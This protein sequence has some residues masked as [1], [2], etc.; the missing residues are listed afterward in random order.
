MTKA[1]ELAKFGRETPPTGVV[2]GDSDT[3]TL[4][5]KTFS[6]GPVFSSGTV[7]AVPYLNASKVFSTSGTF[8]FDGTNLGVGVASPGVKVDVQGSGAGITV[9]RFS[10]NNTD[11]TTALAVFQRNGGAVSASVKYNATNSPLTI[12]FGTT[13]SHALT[14][15]TADTERMRIASGGNVGIGTTVP[16]R[17]LQVGDYSTSAI[18]ALGSSATSTGTICFATSDTAPGRY[19]GTIGYNHQTNAMVFGVNAVEGVTINS[20]GLG[21]GA[22]PTA[23]TGFGINKFLE[24][25]GASV[26]G[27]V[28]RP[29]GSTSE[30]SVL[31]AGDGLLIG[32]AGAATATN[33]VI[34]F[35]TS[36]VNS[37]NASLG[38]RMRIASNGHI[39]IGTTNP[40]SNAPSTSGVLHINTVDVGGWAITHYTN[41][42]TGA[43]AGDGVIIGNIGLDTYIFNY[44]AG[45]IIFGTSGSTKARITSVGV[46]D[47]PTVQTS[48]TPVGTFSASKW[49]T[50]T[51]DTVTT[52][53]YFCGP[54]TTTYGSWEIYNAKSNGTPLIAAAFTADYTKFGIPSSSSE[55]MRITNVGNLAIGTTANTAQK[56]NVNGALWLIASDYASYSTIISPRLDSTHPFTIQTR[57]NDSTMVNWLGIYAGDAGV[58]NRIVLGQGG[59]PVV[60]GATSSR[61]SAKLDIRGDIMV[62]GSNASYY[63]TI[64]YSAGTGLLSLAAENG[65]GISLKSGATERVRITPTGNLVFNPSAGV[66]P[67]IRRNNVNG[68]NGIRIQA[69]AADGYPNDANA[70]SYIH[71]AGGVIGDTYEGSIDIVAYG[72]IVDSNRNQIRFSNRSGTDTVQERMRINH[73]GN[74]GIGTTNPQT[75]FDVR[76]YT[77]NGTTIDNGVTLWNPSGVDNTPIGI[78]FSTYGDENGNQHPKQFIG[79]IRDGAYGAGKGSIVFCNRDAAD[80]SVVTLSDERMRILPG[81]NVGI[82]TTAPLGKLEVAAGANGQHIRIG[83]NNHDASSSTFRYPALSYY[84]RRDNVRYNG[85]PLSDYGSTASIVFTDRPGT[86]GY[87]LNCRSSDIEFWTATNT[88]GTGLDTRPTKRL[89]ISAEGNFLLGTENPNPF[90][91]TSGTGGLAMRP[92]RL[93]VSSDN[94][95]GSFTKIGSDGIVWFWARS[96]YGNVGNVYVSSSGTSYNSTSDYRLKNITGALTGY[97]ERLMGLQP[98]QGTWIADGSEFRGFLAHD[99]ANQYPK[100]VTGE[101]DEIDADG[102]PIMQSMQASTAEVM[103]DLIAMVKDLITENESLKA[104]LDAANL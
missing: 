9:A 65:G 41:G 97:K 103:A 82:G 11:T 93:F 96:G 84:A 80:T 20:N 88:G 95:C 16:Y 79:A 91:D 74:V 73:V 89:I 3:Q 70:G 59:W 102:K 71:L 98:K 34:R 48:G 45:D 87:P 27:L 35:F 1:L 18:M 69:N 10:S 54:N 32:A 37:S 51:E 78:R 62:L 47:T 72:G 83:D 61:A 6:D 66:T 50:Q 14:F 40:I 68:S 26:P 49:F 63:A 5:S 104:R 56:L 38:E 101:K 60:I 86:S 33:N 2:V 17:Q 57:N 46:F 39:G 92:N 85:A 67:V 100:S 99:F 94:D 8:V 90:T 13:T 36:N 7:N 19:V 29:T 53:T 64:D 21:I 81:G 22:A 55:A 15:I 58:D 4:S 28:L 77:T 43:A 52:R 44:E 25:A 76:S 24:I 75:I 31:G 42:S 23:V 30:H 12:D